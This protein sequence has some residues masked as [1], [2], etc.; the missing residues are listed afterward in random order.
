MAGRTQ[1]VLEFVGE[2]SRLSK[3]LRNVEEKTGSV[4][5]VVGK[6]GAGASGLVGMANSALTLGSALTTVA[7]AA[8]ALPGILGGVAVATQTAKLALSGFSD[9][10]GGDAEAMAKLSPAA[11]ASARAVQGLGDGFNFMRSQVQQAFFAGLS[12]EIRSTGQHLLAV[13]QVGLPKVAAGFNGMAREALGAART[14]FF[15]DD[16]A[17][18]IDNTSGALGNMRLTAANALSGFVGLGAVGSDYLPAIGAAADSAAAKF[19]NWV[20]RG[21]ESGRI[22]QLIDGAIAGFRTL[23][24]IIG[25]V[26]ETVGSV[27]SAINSGLGAG[28]TPLDMLLQK[29][30]AFQL[31]LAQ[32]EAQAALTQLGVAIRAVSNAFNAVLPH[33]ITFA[34]QL[35]SVLLPAI[36]SVANVVSANGGLFGGLV[37][38]IAGAAVAIKGILGA[39]A[40]VRAAMTAWQAVH[41]V[42][43]AQW[44]ARWATMAATSIAAMGRLILQGAL[45]VASV[46]A[47]G[48]TALA[49]LAV[50][51]AG[52]VAQWAIMA[53]GAMARAVVMAASWLVAMGPIG[54]AIAAVVGLVALV[55]A[56]WDAVSAATSAAWSAVTSWVSGAWSTI[57]STVSSAASAVVG[58]LTSAWSRATAATS[59]GWAMLTGAV[60][61]GIAAAVGFVRGLPGMIVSALGNLGSLLVNSGRALINGFLN[62]LRSAWNTVVGWAQSAMSWLRSFWP[63]S[64]A[65][66][67]PFSGHGYVTY[68]GQAL[69]G[70]FAASLAAGTPLVGQAAE[71]LMGAAAAPLAGSALA[72]AG[73]PAP[74]AGGGGVSRFELVA[75]PGADSAVASMIMQLIR[76]GKLQIRPV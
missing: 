53:A 59:A 55:I 33:V 47:Q 38:G 34:A 60:R 3:T 45:W 11:Q 63:F 67:G 71:G 16:L 22:N 69:V 13:G 26:A 75:G 4:L 9:A 58:W 35:G 36:T 17:Q 49:S 12:T 43:T 31:A 24:Q 62:G 6:I 2:D 20:D 73:L 48:A 64:P 68:S 25:T 42:F 14:P 19:K 39:F 28:A 32:P 51:A 27:G 5:G 37:I 74:A 56:N 44:V 61:T 18:I 1:V 50:T 54:W 30:Q 40:M 21:V 57:T 66:R 70:D 15:Q 41:A 23:G 76:T 7:P 8:L 52:Y 72:G 65:E 10:V 29:V 46:V